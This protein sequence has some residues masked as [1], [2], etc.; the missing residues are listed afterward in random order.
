MYRYET[1]LHTRE[2][3]ACAS[4]SGREQALLYKKAGYD[5]I[6]ITDHFFRGNTCIHH[7]LPWE[8]RIH[9]FFKGYENAKKTGDEIG[10]KVFSGYEET[11]QG[12][13]FL[14][15]GLSKEW[16]LDHPEMEF[17]TIQEQH[18]AALSQ[19][20]MVIHAHPFRDR[21]YIPQIRL[22][23]NSV[24]GVEVVNYGNH[25]TENQNA[26]K[27]A[28]EYNLPITGGSDGHTTRICGGGIGCDKELNSI[29]DYVKLIKSRENIVLL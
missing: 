24:D 8:E 25:E 22:F 5:G 29:Y 1:H 3:S 26:F 4:A 17:F 14:V 12:T 10:L 23:P 19:G 9:L 27:Y 21:P 7:K 15:Y 20:G 2:A 13:D 28:K 18:E 16:M 6:I 11:F